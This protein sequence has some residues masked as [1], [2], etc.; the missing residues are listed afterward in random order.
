LAAESDSQKPE[1]GET[2]QTEPGKTGLYEDSLVSSETVHVS[3]QPQNSRPEVTQKSVANDF[4]EG[5][6]NVSA[7]PVKDVDDGDVDDDNDYEV[8]PEVF[9]SPPVVDKH[10]M[11][12]DTAVYDT[13]KEEESEKEA[14]SVK[15]EESMKE[16]ESSSAI[17]RSQSVGGSEERTVADELYMN[18][19]NTRYNTTKEEESEEE[20]WKWEELTKGEELN[21]IKPEVT[22]T[23]KEVTYDDIGGS[24]NVSN[25]DLSNTS[26]PENRETKSADVLHTDSNMKKIRNFFLRA[27]KKDSKKGSWSPSGSAVSLGGGDDDARNKKKKKKNKKGTTDGVSETEPG[28]V[29]MA[30]SM[31]DVIEDNERAWVR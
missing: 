9:R 7:P 1:P 21:A 8:F 4:N 11:N 28:N 3:V 17:G 6:R 5:E 18:V 29:R 12:V 22:N 14:E 23:M 30:A 26:V 31:S 27:G 10:Y 24:P 13:M 15:E 25:L 19:V 16:E 2:R 20:S